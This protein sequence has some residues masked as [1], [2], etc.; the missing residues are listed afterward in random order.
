M[1]RARNI[2]PSFFTNENLVELPLEDRLLFIGLWTMAD[3][4]GRMEDRPKR[5]KITLFPADNIDVD[6]SLQRLQEAGF[7]ER[8]QIDG[9]KYIQIWKFEKHQNPHKN[10]A[11]S[12]IPAPEG[13]GASTV[14]APYKHGAAHADSLIPDS[15]IPES[16]SKRAA[17]ASDMQTQ[18]ERNASASNKHA[19]ASK[20]NTTAS[21]F[22]PPTKEEVSEYCK[23]RRSP[24][25]A[26][27]FV[28]FYAAKGWMIG[29][30]KMRD[31]KA[32]VRTWESKQSGEPAPRKRKML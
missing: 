30:N 6:E 8:Y 24:V 32:A 18:C 17:N 28:D 4:S 5:I 19:N 16:S 9:R 7:L 15:L 23:Q 22:T 25:D 1:P 13:Y 31:W 14:Q 29:K 26:Q 10:E 2:K 3:R 20:S 12:S 21:R 27:R 11:H